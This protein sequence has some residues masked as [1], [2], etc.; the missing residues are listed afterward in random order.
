MSGGETARDGE[1]LLGEN[2]A[3]RRRLWRRCKDRALAE[4][5]A[6]PRDPRHGTLTGYNYGCRC[7]RCRRARHEYHRRHW[8]SGRGTCRNVYEERIH[9]GLQC[10]NGF[11]CSE[12]GGV[13]EDDDHYA[14]EGEFNY[15]PR[16]GR[17]VV[18]R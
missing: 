15:C 4:M 10:D 9:P 7:E 1:M 11:M 18:G 2:R 13:V 5:E 17:K 14:I 12:C 6:D 3:Y 16:C 8:L